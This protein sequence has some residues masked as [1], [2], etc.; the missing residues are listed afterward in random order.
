MKRRIRLTESDL[1]RIIKESVNRVLNEDYEFG[2]NE[3]GE[4]GYYSRNYPTYNDRIQDIALS[5][6]EGDSDDMIWDEDWYED[7]MRKD[8]PMITQAI[9]D[10]RCYLDK[11]YA[12]NH[13]DERNDNIYNNKDRMSIYQKFDRV[14]YEKIFKSKDAEKKIKDEKLNKMLDRIEKKYGSLSK[15]PKQITKQIYDIFYQLYDNTFYNREYKHSKNSLN[16]KLI[17]MDKKRNKNQQ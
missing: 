11:N 9:E 4:P 10:R 8:E 5:I 3:Y 2:Y 15:A 1:H 14:P 12:M 6:H 16:R 13:G 17:S 7:M